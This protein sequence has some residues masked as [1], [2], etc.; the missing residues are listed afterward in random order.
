MKKAIIVLCILLCASAVFAKTVT[1]QAG[2]STLGLNLGTTYHIND[3]TKV[4]INASAA[5]GNG[6]DWISEDF[7]LLFGQAL[8]SFDTIS[9]EAND[10]DLRV[11]L[12]YAR[13]GEKYYT[14]DGYVMNYMDAVCATFGV[15][16]THWFGE[17]RTNG[18][19]VGLDLPVG[20]YAGNN[21][22]TENN[23]P[24]F[25]PFSSSATVAVLAASLR[26]G[27]ACQF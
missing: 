22:F 15:Q 12:A 11:G 26:F 24:F 5:M 2:L 7:K 1:I 16:Y 18:I 21:G 23:S 27:Y 20:G 13:M 9:S 25:G 17:K 14:D 19:Y 3:S 8:V 6:I 10:L 4:G